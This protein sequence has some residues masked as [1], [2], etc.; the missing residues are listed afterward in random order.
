VALPE[1]KDRHRVLELWITWRL[2]VPALQAPE[3]IHANVDVSSAGMANHLTADH[4]EGGLRLGDLAQ[5]AWLRFTAAEFTIH[6]VS[7]FAHEDSHHCVEPLAVCRAHKSLRR[8]VC[9]VIRAPVSDPI[10]S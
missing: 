8:T 3:T 5:R 9:A 7:F 4:Y 1:K 6:N 10:R 2:D